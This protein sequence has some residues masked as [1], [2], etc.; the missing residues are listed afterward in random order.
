MVAEVVQVAGRTST[1]VGLA[2][3]TTRR[4][5]VGAQEVVLEVGAVEGLGPA[6]R[7]AGPCRRPECGH[8]SQAQPWRRSVETTSRGR[9]RG[10]GERLDL[11]SC[12]RRGCRWPGR[13]RVLVLVRIRALSS[14][15]E[16]VR[17][18]EASGSGE[19]VLADRQRALISR[20]HAAR[21]E[22]LE[23]AHRWRQAYR[24]APPSSTPKSSSAAPSRPASLLSPLT[25]STKSVRPRLF[26]SV[27]APRT[28]PTSTS[29]LTH[30]KRTQPKPSSPTSS[31]PPT[32][33]PP[34]PSRSTSRPPTAR[35]TPT[36][37]S[38]T[39]S[40]TA[41]A[42]TSPT[43]PPRT[44]PPCACSASATS[45]TSTTSPPTAGASARSTRQRCVEP[46]S[47]R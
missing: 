24:A 16:R 41:S 1:L 35:S 2:V 3:R 22:L 17:T 40:S 45:T 20:H 13:G 36:P 11:L 34:R 23:R 42:S 4:A 21:P 38:A 12:T 26:L 32:T 25:K 44:R 28:A 33:P 46:L 18:R 30:A 7:R 14:W 43:A 15:P 10:E 39:P 5:E 31:R 37:S 9:L 19:L 8:S 29:E 27:T 47:V 6:V